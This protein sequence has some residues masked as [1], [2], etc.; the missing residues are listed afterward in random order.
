MRADVDEAGEMS[1]RQTE[2]TITA[3][4]AAKHNNDIFVPQCKDGPSGSGVAKLDAWAMLR[5]YSRPCMYGY[6][7]KISRSD[8]LQDTKWPKY[9]ALC[10]ELYFVTPT[11]L[12]APE[13][14]PEQVGLM[15][16]AKTG[17]RIYTKKKAQHRQIDE[18]VLLFRYVLYSRARIL[19][20]EEYIGSSAT[21]EY[22]QR[23][24]QKKDLDMEF[25]WKVGKN[26]ARRVKEE[27]N[28]VSDENKDLRREIEAFKEVSELLEEL[29]IEAVSPWQVRQK[30]KA[31]AGGV[32]AV[33]KRQVEDGLRGAERLV[34][35]LRAAQKVMEQG[36]E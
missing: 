17:T 15:W 4:L 6:E 28:K 36:R 9:L 31:M 22:W 12:V 18:P 1:V 32:P 16:V 34:D 30:L 23:W 10:N 25:G 8:F 26:I 19:D 7:I 33:V 14:V 13:E 21:R 27:I 20:G 24:L 35:S 11:G 29:G 5:S 2:K 3:L